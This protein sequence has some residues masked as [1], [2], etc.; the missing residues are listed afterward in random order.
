VVIPVFDE[1]VLLV[2]ETVGI[3]ESFRALRTKFEV[4]ICENGSTDNTLKLAK[5]LQELYPEVR[6]LTYPKP[7]IGKAM[8]MGI[9]KSRG[10]IVI[11]FNI[12]FWDMAFVRE[13]VKRLRDCDVVIGSKTM[14][15][16]EDLRPALRQFITKSFNHFIRLTMGLKCSD[17]H[18]LKALQ[19]EKILPLIEACHAENEIFDTELVIRAQRKGLKIGEVPVKVQEKRPARLS[20]IGRVPRT[21]VDLFQLWRSL[22]SRPAYGL[23]DE[24]GK[25]NRAFFYDSIA[26]EFDEIMNPYDLLKRINIVFDKFLN[27]YQ[28]E[29]RT[30]LDVGCGTGWFSKAAMEKGARVF[31]LDIGKKLLLEVKKKCASRSIQG[32]AL[33]LGF[34][35]GAFDLVICSELIEHTYNPRL[36]IR[37]C[38]RVL[39]TGGH[40]VITVPNRI[41]YPALKIAHLLRIRPYKGLE[42]WVSWFG[43]K[44]WMEE[45]GL[46]IE[47]Q[48]GF[49]AMP[50][51]SSILYPLIDRLDRSF[52]ALGPMMLNIGVL[53]KKA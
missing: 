30:L 51:V 39:K 22:R 29:E 12:D 38:T 6:V 17:T 25:D 27:R 45:E 41:W 21:V 20:L 15:G 34:S 5:S 11:I 18:G 46:R 23:S 7:S 4:L 42:N 9:E 33:N 53:A 36:A 32:D 35:D 31:S 19:R 43:L 16:A 52:E 3:M 24:A 50:F 8:K 14:E 13:A 2:R 10:R 44:K 49:H 28:F 26:S 40:I 37:E 48:I 47:S 1:E